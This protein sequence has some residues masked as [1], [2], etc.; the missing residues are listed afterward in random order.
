MTIFGFNTD[1]KHGDKVYHVESAARAGDLL[2]QTSV[3]VK[4][5]CVGKRM[6]SYAQEASQPGFSEQAIHELLKTQHRSVVEAVAAGN[7]ESALGTAG[8][9]AD[10]GASGFSLKWIRTVPATSRNHIGLQFQVTDS[11]KAIAGAE[12]TARIGSSSDS[13]VIARSA[14]DGAGNVQMEIPVTD[15]LRRE[16]A[17]MVH[18]VHASKS[19]TRKFRLKMGEQS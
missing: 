3:F 5:M 12:V 15:D 13:P 16:P 19:V 9:V 2:V 17:I 11:G 8:E 18:A 7:M 10:I 14:S 6:T 1:V 4:G